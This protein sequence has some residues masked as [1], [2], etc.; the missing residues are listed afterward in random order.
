VT[1]VQG[2]YK[3][4]TGVQTTSPTISCTD[5]Y[6]GCGDGSALLYTVP[7]ANYIVP[8]PNNGYWSFPELAA[9]C[10]DDDYDKAGSILHEVSHLVSDL[11]WAMKIPLSILL[12]KKKQITDFWHYS[13]ALMTT[14]TARLLLR[15]LPLLRRL[16]TLTPTRST[17]AAS[18]SVAA[19]AR[20]ILENIKQSTDVVYDDSQ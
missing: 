4:I 15:S 5:T 10:A 3:S 2:I 14:P 12:L 1:K 20:E 18:D 16:L 19:A 7:S 11:Y 6:S 17:L 8:C 9:D 13:T